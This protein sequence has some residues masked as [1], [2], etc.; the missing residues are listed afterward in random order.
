MILV[1]MKF[2]PKVMYFLSKLKLIDFFG[3]KIDILY[4]NSKKYKI[5]E[6]GTYAGVSLIEMMRRIPN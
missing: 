4:D 2:Y 6:I 5:L 1:F 3:H